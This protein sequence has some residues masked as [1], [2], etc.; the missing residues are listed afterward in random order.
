MHKNISQESLY[1][2]EIYR[3]NDRAQNR[4]THFARAC[5]MHLEI[6]QEPLYTT[7]IYRK[8]AR[9]QNRDTHFVR[10]AVEMHWDF[11]ARAT[12]Y[13]NLQ[14]KGRRPAGAPWSSIGLYSHRK[15]PSVWTHCLGKKS[16][17]E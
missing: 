3:K 16:I 17:L 2:T 9:A 7:E 4:D 11:T 12:L 5:A 13:G 14:V 1:T 10:A 6:S 8:N 15:N